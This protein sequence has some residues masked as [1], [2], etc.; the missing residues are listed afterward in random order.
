MDW[1]CF[2]REDLIVAFKELGHNLSYCSVI[3]HE[4]IVKFELDYIKEVK[5]QIKDD[6]I[7][8]AFSMNYYPSV[9]EACKETGT[10]YIAWVY[11]N[12][13][14]QL[15]GIN[16]INDCNYIFTFNSY[17][18]DMLQKKHVKTVSYAPLATN[19]DRLDKF[20]LSR[21]D[22]E[23]YGGEV[24]FV[25]SFYNEKDD[26]YGILAEQLLKEDRRKTLGY[27]DGLMEAQLKIYGKTFL[28]RCL[29][30]SIIK[31]IME[32]YPYYKTYFTYFADDPY[33]YA[34]VIGKKV[35]ELE[36]MGF[37]EALSYHVNVKVFTQIKG[38]VLGNC[39][40][41][42]HVH[43]LNKAPNVYKGSKINLNITLRTIET[44]IPFRAIEIM[45]CGGFMITN[46]QE[47]FLLHF[48]PD[49]DF[50]FYESKEDLIEKCKFYLKHDTE[51]Q[52]IAK[53]AHDRVVSDHTFK[54]RLTE[55]LKIVF[56]DS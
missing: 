35:T 8:V 5:Q 48:E 52:R 1:K 49:K 10:P 19:T 7:D 29:T 41:N 36:R 33:I 39:E 45:G 27:I 32:V 3:G 13:F 40:V 47:D 6:M 44:G 16:I 25:G 23:K 54:K 22:R 56:P 2:G 9:S 38:T 43:Y 53:H 55:M 24:S 21:S 42:G 26:Y 18:R 30:D 12:P 14:I 37:L 4:F 50:V 31:T 17:T 46:Y 20:Y 51:R 15:Y 28:F 11:D 34:W